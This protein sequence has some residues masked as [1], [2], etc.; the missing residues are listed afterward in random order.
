[1][2]FLQWYSRIF[3]GL[4]T[5]TGINNLINSKDNEVGTNLVT[6]MAVVLLL[7]FTIVA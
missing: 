7:I 6:L 4:M 1:M 2:V 5:I 3:V